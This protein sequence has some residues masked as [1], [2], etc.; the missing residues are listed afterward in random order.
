MR[1]VHDTVKALFHS[2]HENC[3]RNVTFICPLVK[4]QWCCRLMVPRLATAS[5]CVKQLCVTEA[6]PPLLLR[7]IMETA[8]VK[9]AP[10]AITGAQEN[11]RLSLI[12]VGSTGLSQDQWLE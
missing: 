1:Q 8:V 10:T 2:Q 9:F 5:S 3:A 6:A 12:T 4:E 7:G 11:K